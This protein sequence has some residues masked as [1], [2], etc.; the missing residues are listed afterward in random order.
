MGFHFRSTKGI[1]IVA[2]KYNHNEN[3]AAAVSLRKELAHNSLQNMQLIRRPGPEV[4]RRAFD[5]NCTMYE[6]PN[7]M[8]VVNR[9]GSHLNPGKGLH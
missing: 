3:K 9:I 2:I 8:R 7:T 5:P 6:R 4:G 1:V